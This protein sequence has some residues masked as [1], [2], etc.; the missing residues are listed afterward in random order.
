MDA[1]GGSTTVLTDKD[2]TIKILPLKVFNLPSSD[3]LKQ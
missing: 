1:Y 3:E 2:N